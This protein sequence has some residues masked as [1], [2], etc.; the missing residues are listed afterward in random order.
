MS[1]TFTPEDI[2]NT[3]I[4]ASVPKV[5]EDS[6]KPFSNLLLNNFA[7]IV[8]LLLG[9]VINYAGVRIYKPMASVVGFVIGGAVTYD[10]AISCLRWSNEWYIGLASI[11]IGIVAAVLCWFF[12]DWAITLLGGVLCYMLSKFIIENP[13]FIR[14]VIFNISSDS[15]TMSY[16]MIGSTILLTLIFC[17]IF[18]YLQRRALT[19]VFSASGSLITT[20]SIK[21]LLE[22]NNQKDTLLEKI[23]RMP[24]HSVGIVRPKDVVVWDYLIICAFVVFL[25]SGIFVQWRYQNKQDENELVYSK[26]ENNMI[27]MV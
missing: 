13:V 5:Y 16:L 19:L 15:K 24:L 26:N 7:A 20:D 22:W 4:L 12:I 1:Q 3:S 9:L 27:A 23:K 8:T 6:N 11:A 21:V 17:V 14:Y 18:W 2:E 10:Y 25:I